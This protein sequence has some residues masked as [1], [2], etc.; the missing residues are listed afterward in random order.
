MVA[1]RTAIDKEM[2]CMASC[3]EGLIQGTGNS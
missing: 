2:D 1:T 3:I